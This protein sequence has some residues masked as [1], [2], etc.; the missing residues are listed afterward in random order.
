MDDSSKTQT[1]RAKREVN[2]TVLGLTLAIP[3]I[4]A[5]LI[6][7]SLEVPSALP[8]RDV[9]LVISG[10]ML[11]LGG[12][13]IE[14]YFVLAAERVKH[15]APAGKAD[16]DG[17]TAEE[18]VA[19]GRAEA[20]RKQEL[21]EESRERARR[22]ELTRAYHEELI[23]KTYGP[24]CKSGIEDR[25]S[26]AGYPPS[27]NQ[28]EYVWIPIGFELESDSEPGTNPGLPMIRDALAHLDDETSEARKKVWDGMVDYNDSVKALVRW[29]SYIAKMIYNECGLREA[30]GIDKH[31]QESK[32]D[33]S[34]L[35]EYFDRHFYRRE[36]A[37]I[38]PPFKGV[39]PSLGWTFLPIHYAGQ[40]QTLASSSDDSELARLMKRI[41]P[42][43]EYYADARRSLDSKRESLNTDLRALQS[44]TA[45]LIQT[46]RFRP[47]LVK[48]KCS[49]EE[50][51]TEGKNQDDREVHHFPASI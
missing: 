11:G 44:G 46:L 8:D 26:L 25:E 9:V 22:N 36:S 1:K 17:Y 21:E 40:D 5:I 18:I 31:P 34:A 30:S 7:V 38:G 45:R 23:T 51:F 33:V 13:A 14:E 35:M 29:P 49:V 16:G 37:S 3:I 47:H 43:G 4:G 12:L 10:V 42:W 50:S 32:C 39:G 48:G 20:E 6:I 15:G 19:I 2:K 27:Q 41:D 24:W 28:P